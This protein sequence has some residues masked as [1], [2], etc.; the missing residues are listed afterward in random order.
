MWAS[1][2]DASIWMTPWESGFEVSVL[3]SSSQQLSGSGLWTWIRLIGCVAR[4]VVTFIHC[5][6][7]GH[8]AHLVCLWLFGPLS[9]L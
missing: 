6:F 9:V 7:L 4:L 5:W 3:A 8:E 2:V 1:F